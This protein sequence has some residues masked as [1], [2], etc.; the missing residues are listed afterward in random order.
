MT[1]DQLPTDPEP[2]YLIVTDHRRSVFAV[3]GPMTDTRPW[4]DAATYAQ[5]HDRR[6]VCGPTGPDRDALAAEYRDANR[7]LA[8]VPPGTIIRPRAP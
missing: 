6:V 4:D 2:F 7:L 1:A 8:G 5:S 3:E